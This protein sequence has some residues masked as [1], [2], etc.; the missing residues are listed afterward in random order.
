[1]YNKIP[2]CP[3]KLIYTILVNGKENTEEWLGIDEANN[4]LMLK[5]DS[6]ID[7]PVLVGV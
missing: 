1:M 3:D 2:N 5:P 7:S 4:K 6:L